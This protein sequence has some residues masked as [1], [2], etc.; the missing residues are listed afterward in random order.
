M[1]KR[2]VFTLATAVS[3]LTDL[4][5]K[6]SPITT[7][8][9]VCIYPGCNRYSTTRSSSPAGQ[10]IS[11][12]RWSCR[13]WSRVYQSAVGGLP[14]WV[15]SGVSDVCIVNIA[16]YVY[17]THP[18]AI[19]ASAWIVRQLFVIVHTTHCEYCSCTFSHL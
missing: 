4:T 2:A 11:T 3:S 15:L 13:T 16:H 14:K 7:V 9:I 8:L 5:D 10:T 18:S 1:I 12:R 6:G 19:A 17:I